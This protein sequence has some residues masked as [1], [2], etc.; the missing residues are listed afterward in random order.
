MMPK[1]YLKGSYIFLS[2]DDGVLE[3]SRQYLVPILNTQIN[4]VYPR[5]RRVWGI[6]HSLKESHR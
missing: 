1:Y 3:S 2:L 6:Y 5:Q 4:P